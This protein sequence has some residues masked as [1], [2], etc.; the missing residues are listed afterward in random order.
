MAQLQSERPTNERHESAHPVV[1]WDADAVPPEWLKLNGLNRD[2][3]ERPKPH[4]A[5][6]NEFLRRGTT[7]PETNL[8]IRAKIMYQLCKDRIPLE[9]IFVYFGYLRVDETNTENPL[10][11][12]DNADDILKLFSW[13]TIFERLVV[14][15]RTPFSVDPGRATRIRAFLVNTIYPQLDNPTHRE[16]FEAV[17]KIDGSHSDFEP[18]SPKTRKD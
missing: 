16:I 13:T 1:S 14:M 3:S 15:L 6:M 8:Y 10:E 2:G 12:N 5:A 9:T 11:F 4:A 17:L 18:E 7:C